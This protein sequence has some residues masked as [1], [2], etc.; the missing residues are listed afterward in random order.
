MLSTYHLHIR[1]TVDHCFYII[2]QIHLVQILGWVPHH[3]TLL[4]KQLGEHLLISRVRWC[5]YGSHLVST[6]REERDRRMCSEASNKG[7]EFGGCSLG[8][9][10]GGTCKSFPKLS[11]VALIQ[12]MD[13]YCPM[14]GEVSRRVHGF[15]NDCSFLLI[16]ANFS[17]FQC[18]ASEQTCATHA[19][20]NEEH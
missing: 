2:C 7:N 8:V 15:P 1:S 16:F 17:W 10:D 12:S 5:L 6:T 19:T 4:L 18:Q 20:K 13:S 3:P 9:Q 11:H 14:T